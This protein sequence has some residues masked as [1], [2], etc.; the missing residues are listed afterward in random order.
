MRTERKVICISLLLHPATYAMSPHDR[1]IF[2][3]DV[4]AKIEVHL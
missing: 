1:S 2:R 3:V 4:R